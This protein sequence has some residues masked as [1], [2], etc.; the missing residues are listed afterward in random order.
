LIIIIKVHKKKTVAM[1]TEQT[2]IPHN[3]HSGE[4]TQLTQRKDPEVLEYKG[5]KNSRFVR[6]A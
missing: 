6:V 2:L 5:A 1:E 4:E 3:N